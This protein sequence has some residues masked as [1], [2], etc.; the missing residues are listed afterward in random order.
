MNLPLK[1]A[2]EMSNGSMQTNNKMTG[3]IEPSHNL[4]RKELHM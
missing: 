1:V 3:F 4:L 2:W